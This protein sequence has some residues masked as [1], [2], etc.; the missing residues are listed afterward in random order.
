MRGYRNQPNETARALR[1]GWL[2][3][4]DIGVLHEDG[5]L[6]VLDRRCDLIV[7]GGENVYPAEIESV[8][9]EHAAVAEAAV[10]RCDDARYG[11]RPVA[12]WVAASSNAEVDDEALRDFCRSRLASFKVPV[13]FHR[14]DALP[15]TSAGKLLRRR[16]SES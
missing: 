9:L 6:T 15:R 5:T 8:L 4:G 10:G 12:W 1:G 2:H 14:V 11:S 3:T 7:S 16:L 13:R